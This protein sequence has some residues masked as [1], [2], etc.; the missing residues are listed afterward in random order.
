MEENIVLN[1]IRT[2]CQKNEYSFYKLSK[3]SGV[4]LST[5]CSLYEK[6]QFPSI[7]TLQKICIALH[8]TVSDFFQFEE[9]PEYISEE[10]KIL[11]NKYNS[12]N[13]TQKHFL[14]AY[15]DGLSCHR[16]KNGY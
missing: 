10:H 6:N 1:K 8:T 3:E 15:L 13:I 5:I 16:C 11:I 4:P 14:D 7:P 2:L 12:L 9:S